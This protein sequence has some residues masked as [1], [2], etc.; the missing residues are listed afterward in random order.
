MIMLIWSISNHCTRNASN[1][2]HALKFRANIV[3]KWELA[4]RIGIYHQ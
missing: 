1:H 2:K 3:K 4:K